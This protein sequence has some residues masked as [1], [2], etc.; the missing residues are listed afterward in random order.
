MGEMLV[1]AATSDEAEAA[2]A[3]VAQDVSHDALD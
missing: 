3:A 1:D 2:G